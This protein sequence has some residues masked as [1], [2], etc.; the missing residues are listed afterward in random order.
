MVKIFTNI[1]TS[2]A[3]FLRSNRRIILLITITI[4]STLIISAMIS[5]FLSRYTNLA[6]P[7]V[8]NIRTI[9][10]EAYWDLDCENKTEIVEWG[11]IFPGLSISKN[12]YLKSISNVETTLNLTALNWNPPTISDYINLSWSYNGKLLEPGEVIQVTIT[13]SASSSNSLV[14]YLITNEVRSFDFNIDIVSTET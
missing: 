4:V 3:N 8:G 9:G 10:A 11:T 13:L 12:L 5:I 6:I 14:Q 1:F 2:P 7:S